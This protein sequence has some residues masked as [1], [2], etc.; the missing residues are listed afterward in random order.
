MAVRLLARPPSPGQHFDTQWIITI[1][2][3]VVAFS[4]MQLLHGGT[5]NYTPLFALPV[6][7]AAVLGS[8]LLALGTAAAVTLLLLADAWWIS[9]HLRRPKRQPVFL[10]AAL[11]ATGLFFVAFLT[12]QL[13]SRLA[14]EEEAARRNARE[15]RVQTR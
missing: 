9:L 2:V 5:I 7:L 13:A 1:A 12:N 11:T 14:R 15:V 3:D 8:R 6:L 4:A 10:Q